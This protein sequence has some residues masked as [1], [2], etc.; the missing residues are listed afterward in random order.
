MLQGF[1]GTA[2]PA[3]ADLILL[4]EVTMGMGLLFGAFLARKKRYRAH[5]WC[6]SSL[7]ILNLVLIAMAMVPSFRD[8]VE[9]KIPAKLA[10]SYYTL[11]TVHAALGSLA[12]V[13][14][15]Y[16]LLAAGTDFLPRRLKMSNFKAGMRSVLI[17]WWLALLLGLAT[18]IRWYVPHSPN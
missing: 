7:V 10:R 16:I 14:G 18:Y 17:L 8:H 13:A 5:A 2:A 9:P 3:S 1:L 6:Q 4:L 12:E 15:L 11:A